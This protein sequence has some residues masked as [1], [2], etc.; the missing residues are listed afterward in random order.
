MRGKTLRLAGV[1]AAALWIGLA[2]MGARTI[3]RAQDADSADISPDRAKPKPTPEIPDLAGNWTGTAVVTKT[4]E[5][6]T[7]SFVIDQNKGSLHGTWSVVGGD[8]GHF[9]GSVNAKDAVTMTLDNPKAKYPN[10]KINVTGV[11]SDD[12]TE[13][14][15]SWKTA[16]CK[17]SETGTVQITS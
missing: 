10:C 7:I 12:A 16:S 6:D 8:S 17:K 9:T 3:A 1:V 14:A 2:V 13:I 11:V 4:G 5:I 15:G